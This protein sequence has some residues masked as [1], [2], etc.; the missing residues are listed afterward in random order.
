[1]RSARI[2]NL[3]HVINSGEIGRAGE[4]TL[5]THRASATAESD[6]RLEDETLLYDAID[7]CNTRYNDRVG[8]A[9]LS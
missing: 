2:T 1:M 6:C 5:E 8:A 7:F 4:L 9:L 3:T